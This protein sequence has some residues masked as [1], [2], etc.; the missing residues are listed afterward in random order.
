MEYTPNEEF[1]E[2]VDT[3]LL[4][5]HRWFQS[6][7]PVSLLA[8]IFYLLVTTV[9]SPTGII[10]LVVRALLIAFFTSEFVVEFLLYQNKKEFVKQH[11]WKALLLFP[12]L[13]VLRL[14]GQLAQVVMIMPLFKIYEESGK[15]FTN[16]IL[17][18]NS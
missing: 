12:V 10:D 3:R 2:D 14:L 17:N 6:L 8:V 15:L 11:I 1:K 18:E 13:G 16:Y 5:L 7:A 9:T 4:R